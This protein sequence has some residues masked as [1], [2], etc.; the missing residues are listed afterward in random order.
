[1]VPTLG[2]L[3]ALWSLGSSLLALRALSVLVRFDGFYCKAG[4]AALGP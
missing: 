3:A 4:L 1:M 2:G